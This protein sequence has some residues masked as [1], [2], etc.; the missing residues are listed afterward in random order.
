MLAPYCDRLVPTASVAPQWSGDGARFWYRYGA[1]YVLVEPASGLRRD[2]FDH[3]RLAAAL[4]QASG[5]AV[6]PRR[7]AADDFRAVG[8]QG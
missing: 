4:S 2:A 6:G 7:G 8:V 3:E 5:R 1:R